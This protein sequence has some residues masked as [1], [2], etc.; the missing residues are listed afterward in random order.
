MCRFFVALNLVRASSFQV[1]IM[2]KDLVLT[3]GR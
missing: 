1:I 2:K 3:N